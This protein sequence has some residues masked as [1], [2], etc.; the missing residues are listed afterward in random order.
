MV[1][2]G[3]P[4]GRRRRVSVQIS[5]GAAELP[6]AVAL[7]AVEL[8]HSWRRTPVITRHYDDWTIDRWRLEPR[9]SALDIDDPGGVEPAPPLWKDLALASA[10]ALGLWM[11]AV[12]IFG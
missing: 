2:C 1:A 7:R 6:V 4:A 10:V 8:L 3:T 5:S 12:A 9:L 11:A